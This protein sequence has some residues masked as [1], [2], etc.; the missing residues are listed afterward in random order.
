VFRNAKRLLAGK[1]LENIVDP[2]N[3]Y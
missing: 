3:Q 2:V 1:P